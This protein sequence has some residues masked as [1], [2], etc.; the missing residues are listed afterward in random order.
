MHS[1]LVKASGAEGGFAIGLHDLVRLEALQ[2]PNAPALTH[3]A[4]TLSYAELWRET[5]NV[6]AGLS[7]LG[8]R[9]GDRVGI[10]L[11]K[12]VETVV[13]VLA[14]SALG[15]V[16]VPINPVL[17]PQQV[18]H[19]LTDCAV[20]A[21][22]TSADRLTGLSHVTAHCPSL[23]WAVTIPGR[24][25]EPVDGLLVAT[26]KQLQD[27]TQALSE[28]P[29]VDSDVAAIFYT[30]GSTGLPKGVVLSQRNLLVGAESVSRYLGN[31]ADDV[32]LAALPLSFDAGFSQV[33]TAFQVGA[34]V[35]LLN[36]LGAADVVR[37]CVRYGVTGL[38]CVPPLWIQL[39]GATWPPEATATLRYMANTG[40]RLP[41]ATLESM[42]ALF[43]TA[44]PFLMYGLTEAFRSTYLDPDQVDRRPSSI[45]T[46]IPNAEVLVVRPDGSLCEPDEPGEL[47]HRGPLVS[48]GYW[49]DAIRTAERFKP[50]PGQPPELPHP[51]MAV[52]SGDTV[53]RDEEGY[54][55]F[56]GRSDEMIKTSGYRVS[57]TEIEEA[58]Y[59]TGMVRDVVALGLPDET[60]GQR[61]ELVAS[62]A[63]D[64]VTSEGLVAAL[65]SHLPLYMLP[66]QVTMLAAMPKNPNGKLDRVAVR[67]AVS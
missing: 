47:V 5:A 53:V 22:I 57:P 19:I 39:A 3:K 32:I 63:N 66:K 64:E 13:T 65:R 36:Y 38:T 45:G 52:W 40:G 67:E 24:E 30:S 9:R 15:A 60:L 16:F 23:R 28:A 34:H 2:H 8:I 54:L 59:A 46:A 43:P 17:R 55:Y 33:T 37:A 48:L 21:L 41:R 31:T 42:R 14:A 35:V 7:A 61:I 20:T 58:A 10:Y 4:R 27:G 29:G 26:W 62:A 50:S 11:D 25:P 12:R 44:R 18:A 1:S 51:E 56:V 49:N 6:G